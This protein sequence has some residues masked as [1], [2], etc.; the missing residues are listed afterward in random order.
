M[1]SLSAVVDLMIV[2]II[3]RDLS[4]WIW[5]RG[6]RDV[7]VASRISQRMQRGCGGI[8]PH[9][10]SPEHG[11]PGLQAQSS[12]HPNRE[13]YIRALKRG[14][15]SDECGQPLEE[16][17]RRTDRPT[18]T[19]SSGFVGCLSCGCRCV[20]GVKPKARWTRERWVVR[21]MRNDKNHGFDQLLLLKLS[22]QQRFLSSTQWR[23]CFF[24]GGRDDTVE[25]EG[26]RYKIKDDVLKFWVELDQYWTY[27]QKGG[28]FKHLQKVS[29]PVTLS[30]RSYAQW[31]DK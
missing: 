10:V 2:A 9:G 1:A 3:S 30:K 27:N 16:E 24:K 11:R 14:P 12:N 31:V 7:A 15:G 6:I 26:A 17:L 28:V 22:P 13:S 25:V 20:L 19:L 23:V 29:F 21:K 18:S 8:S 5:T 4:W